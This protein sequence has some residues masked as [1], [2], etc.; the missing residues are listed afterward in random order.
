MCNDICMADKEHAF[1]NY[2][3]FVFPV[4]KLFFIFYFSFLKTNLEPVSHGPLI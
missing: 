3:K 4:A 1:V 2:S